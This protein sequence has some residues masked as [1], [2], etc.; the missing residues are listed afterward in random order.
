MINDNNPDSFEKINFFDY[1]SLLF[2]H[3]GPSFVTPDSYRKLSSPDVQC[4]ESNYHGIVEADCDQDL[5]N[6]LS[7]TPAPFFR[8]FRGCQENTCIIPVNGADGDAG[9]GSGSGCC[10]EVGGGAEMAKFCHD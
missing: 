5:D 8:N 9:G 7:E 3:E 2:P 10:S 1:I 6:Y 4:D